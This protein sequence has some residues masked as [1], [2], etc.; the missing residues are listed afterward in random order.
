[1]YPTLLFVNIAQL[2]NESIKL[3]DT[4]LLRFI[5]SGALDNREINK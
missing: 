1:M 5:Q 2:N 3:H 4:T